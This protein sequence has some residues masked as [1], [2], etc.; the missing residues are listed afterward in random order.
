MNAVVDAG[1]AG[2]GQSGA[3]LPAKVTAH[4]ALRLR[5]N[6]ID[7]E[8]TTHPLF[9]TTT[10]VSTIAHNTLLLFGRCYHARVGSL[11]GALSVLYRLM[12]TVD[13]RSYLAGRK[14]EEEEEETSP[15]MPRR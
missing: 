14:K 11:D 9:T 8:T 10:T 2:E 4:D 12:T 1:G 13:R 15:S 3:D 6:A 7:S 5:L